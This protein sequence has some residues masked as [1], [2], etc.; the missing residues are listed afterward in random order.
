M[1]HPFLVA[2]LPGR[3]HNCISKI[4]KMDELLDIVWSKI[5][6]GVGSIFTLVNR[7]LAPL[8]VMGPVPVI[9]LLVLITVVATKFFSR[10]YTTKRYEALKEEF[11]HWFNLRKE[12]L[13]CQDRE[14]GKLLA[15]NIDQAKLNKLY[16]DFFFEGLLKNILT[17]Y[18]PCLIVAAY[19]NE[20]YQPDNLMTKFGRN[21]VVKIDATDGDTVLLGALFCYVILLLAAY[22]CW[23]AAGKVIARNNHGKK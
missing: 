18:L 12:A 10:V 6:L 13:A 19:I 22:L 5:V 1:S 9:V 7:I 23:Y 11:T 17:T 8:E 16:Y 20:A 2:N 21:Y 14:K 15:R 4:V 3:P